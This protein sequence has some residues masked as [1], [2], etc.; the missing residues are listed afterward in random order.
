MSKI[1]WRRGETRASVR[2][3]D[4][5]A[6]GRKRH[7][8]WKGPGRKGWTSRGLGGLVR[9]YHALEGPG[10][11]RWC[12]CCLDI[13]WRRNARFSASRRRYKRVTHRL[14]RIENRRLCREG[15]REWESEG[16]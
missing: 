8:L 11:R 4:P 14:L 9:D 3:R 10:H 13:H 1:S 6:W 2:R 7:S 16:D 12:P 15:L 5:G